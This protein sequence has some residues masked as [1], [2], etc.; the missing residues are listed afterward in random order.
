MISINFERIFALFLFCF[1][2]FQK[3]IMFTLQNH[4]RIFH[5]QISSFDDLIHF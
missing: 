5:F 1:E 4:L 2:L 3:I